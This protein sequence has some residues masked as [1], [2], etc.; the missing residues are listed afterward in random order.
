M[1]RIEQDCIVGGVVHANVHYCSAVG[2]KSR[3]E[4][5]KVLVL[6]K[7]ALGRRSDFKSGAVDLVSSAPSILLPSSNT[8]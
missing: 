2:E 1:P 7:I 5:Y 8:K 6:V 3:Q 4:L